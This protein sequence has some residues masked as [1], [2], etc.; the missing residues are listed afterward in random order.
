MLPV[1]R[2]Q[3]MP[4]CKPPNGVG[5]APQGEEL[6]NNRAAVAG[7]GAGKFAIVIP[8]APRAQGGVDQIVIN[9][10]KEIQRTGP[11]EPLVI[12]PDWGSLLPQERDI[13][14]CRSILMRLR[15]PCDG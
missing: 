6:T 4:V 13:S 14:S 10:Y 12:V 15:T 2:N 11:F 8:W 3:S 1:L 5:D 9:L 7:W